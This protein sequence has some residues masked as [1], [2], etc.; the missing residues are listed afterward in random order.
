MPVDFRKTLSE[1]DIRDSVVI[2]AV[3]GTG[4]G[5]PVKGDIAGMFSFLNSSGAPV[6]AVDIPSG[7]SSDTG[8]VL[9]AAVMA[10][11]TVTFGLPKRGHFFYPGPEYTGRLFIEDIGFPRRC[12]NLFPSKLRWSTELRLPVLFLQGAGILIKV[13]TVMF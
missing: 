6:I 2:D 13:I 5:R 10:D 4:L 1:K 9:G 3:F 8:E 7:I 12:L 11:S